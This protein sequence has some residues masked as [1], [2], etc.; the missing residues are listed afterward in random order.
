MPFPPKS[1]KAVLTHPY[2]NFLLYQHQIQGK[3][4]GAACTQGTTVVCQARRSKNVF[5]EP[6]LC[7]AVKGC[8][9]GDEGHAAEHPSCPAGAG[10]TY[11]RCPG[12]HFERFKLA[13][14]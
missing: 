2:P 13:T 5:F 9:A 12:Y 7:T 10:L 3:G 11:C 14:S 1:I 4:E 6:L 8:E